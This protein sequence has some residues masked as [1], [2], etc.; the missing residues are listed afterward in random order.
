MLLRSSAFKIE[1]MLSGV[2]SRAKAGPERSR[3]IPR[4]HSQA[5]GS[6]SC[7]PRDC[8]AFAHGCLP[9]AISAAL[10]FAAL[11]SSTARRT[12][13][14]LAALAANEPAGLAGA[15]AGKSRVEHPTRVRFPATRRK[16]RVA[17]GQHAGFPNLRTVQQHT[18]LAGLGPVAADG[19]R[20][21]CST[22]EWPSARRVHPA[23]KIT[24]AYSAP[25]D[26]PD[27]SSNRLCAG[28]GLHS[29]AR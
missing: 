16:H 9:S 24:P 6:L 18:S 10:R 15:A 2:S 8:P 27:S 19:T 12:T 26:D 25:Q 21:G 20:V 29:L 13:S 5:S 1:V 14:A 4:Q 3:S 17:R 22:R 7:L 23:P 28:S 11:G